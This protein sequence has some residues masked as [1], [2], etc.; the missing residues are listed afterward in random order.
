MRTTYIYARYFPKPCS[1]KSHVPGERGVTEE[2]LVFIENL[3]GKQEGSFL[4]KPFTF[5]EFR[6]AY[7]GSCLLAEDKDFHLS[8]LPSKD[9]LKSRFDYLYHHQFLART[10][11]GWDH[12]ELLHGGKPLNINRDGSLER[13]ESKPILPEI[14]DEVDQHLSPE[15]AAW[16]AR[17]EEAVKKEKKKEE[18][19]EETVMYGDFK[20]EY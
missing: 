5:L 3:W 11:W 1:L 12:W 19:E 7:F 18:E 8:N 20:I 2:A 4:G 16:L 17:H 14:V 15:D 13:K 9:A 6:D 10:R